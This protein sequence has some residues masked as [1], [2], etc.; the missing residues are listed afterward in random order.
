MGIRPG[1]EWGRLVREPV[2]KGVTSAAGQSAYFYSRGAAFVVRETRAWLGLIAHKAMLAMNA[3]E[4]QRDLNPYSYRDS[5]G[6]LAL[7]LAEHPIGWPFGVIGPFAALGLLL[8]ALEWRR[9]A[10]LHLV[11]IAQAAALLLCFVTSR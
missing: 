10:L 2:S 9:L 6:V 3:R 1:E 5:S 11:L 8:L 7:L 4:V